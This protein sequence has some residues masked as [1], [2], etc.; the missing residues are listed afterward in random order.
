MGEM[1]SLVESLELSA[2]STP[3]FIIERVTRFANIKKPI[4]LEIK[5][6]ADI[7]NIDSEK[8]SSK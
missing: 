2:A 1:I 6:N 4:T 3:K 7:P 5:E 8:I